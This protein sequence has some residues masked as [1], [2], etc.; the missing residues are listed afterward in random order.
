MTFED[1]GLIKPRAY[2]Q[3]T[4]IQEKTIPAVL[5]GK[6]VLASSQTGTG[7]TA[8]FA[9]PLLQKLSRGYTA[10][11][12]RI[13][14]LIL[15]P[16]RE[17]ASQIDAS[18]EKYGKG[19][20]V[21]HLA[22]FGGVKINPQ[23]SQLG[24]GV[25]ILVATPGRLLDLYDKK[26]VR[27]T[28]L[29]Y[30]ILDEADRMLNMGFSEEVNRILSLIESK[31]QSLL[32]SAT[33]STEIK[34]LAAN[35][36]TDPELIQMGEENMT[37]PLVEQ[38][39]YPVDNTNKPALFIELLREKGGVKTLV[40]VRTKNGADRLVMR[41]EKE[42]IKACAIHGDK[43][44]GARTRAIREFK[45]G[46]IDILIATDLAARG[47]D[48]ARLPLVIN[49]HLPHIKEDYIHRI[50]RTGRADQPGTAL[51]LVCAEEF[52]TLV[53]IERLTQQVIPRCLKEGFA[54]TDELPPSKL[55]LRPFKPKK[56]KKK[57]KQT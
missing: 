21:T 36:L 57:K 14:A 30:L 9:L 26:S 2:A 46:E 32:F 18:L 50:G 45:S 29:K 48:I 37:A 10:R 5:S 31:P 56:P 55:D 47:L 13:R 39:V 12:K 17:L 6:D 20:P 15:A 4:P 53:D 19:L 23:M 54:P 28:D 42:G 27:F 51:S 7:K 22:V 38:R 44:Q 35:I 11:P 24:R 43:S 41:L 33:L 34:N 8:A 49:Y 1:L 16:T 40:F 52:P 25:D 3:P